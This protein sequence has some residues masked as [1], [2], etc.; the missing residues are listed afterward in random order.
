[1]FNLGDDVEDVGL[2]ENVDT[3]QVVALPYDVEVM[4]GQ[5]ITP[6]QLLVEEITIIFEGEDDE[7]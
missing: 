3:N 5:I 6:T 1:M 2:R 4:D 7:Q